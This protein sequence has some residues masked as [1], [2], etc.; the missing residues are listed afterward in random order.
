[1][2]EM[3][4]RIDKAILEKYETIKQSG[5]ILCGIEETYRQIRFENP[6]IAVYIKKRMTQIA[7]E[8]GDLPQL[9]NV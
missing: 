5:K 6:E 1:M 7:R 3:L 8:K 2:Q 4:N 9:K